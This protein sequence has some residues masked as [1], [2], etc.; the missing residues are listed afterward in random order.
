[1][2]LRSEFEKKNPWKLEGFQIFLE[3][4]LKKTENGTWEDYRNGIDI[5]EDRDLTIARI[6]GTDIVRGGHKDVIGILSVYLKGTLK[7]NIKR[8]YFEDHNNGEGPFLDE[9]DY[10]YELFARMIAKECQTNEALRQKFTSIY[11]ERYPEEYRMVQKFAATYD[12]EKNSEQEVCSLLYSIYTRATNFDTDPNETRGFVMYYFMIE[13]SIRRGIILP[14]RQVAPL[15]WRWKYPG[16]ES[17][18][19]S[20][21]PT[22]CKVY[23][24][25]NGLSPDIITG[26]PD[27][28]KEAAEITMDDFAPSLAALGKRKAVKGMFR[29]SFE[30]RIRK[31]NILNRKYVRERMRLVAEYIGCEFD[32]EDLDLSMRKIAEKM[33]DLGYTEGLWKASAYLAVAEKSYYKTDFAADALERSRDE[34]KEP[35]IDMLANCVLYIHFTAKLEA[36]LKKKDKS[37]DLDNITRHEII[38][39]IGTED[40]HKDAEFFIN[41]SYVAGAFRAQNRTMEI[42]LDACDLLGEANISR[43]GYQAVYQDEIE[44]KARRIADQEAEIA[45]L[46]N[47]IEALS[48][49]GSQKETGSDK[50]LL[51]EIRKLEE[52][53]EKKD[54]EIDEAEKNASE[55]LSYIEMMEAT[56]TD[57]EPEEENPVDM[58]RLRQKRFVFVCQDVDNI[59]P[60][61][62]REFPGSIFME[63]LQA[64]PAKGR[65]D[66]VVF[67]TRHISHSLYYKAKSIYDGRRMI[68]FTKKNTDEMYRL[69]TRELKTA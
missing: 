57:D 48:K 60:D 44:R 7:S 62:R 9:K 39:E 40:I 49:G 15:L 36:I 8:A 5:E 17:T 38:R 69:I 54:K 64:A 25:L 26:S 19:L 67:V 46:K 50:A 61:L 11:I 58:E 16:T 65:I 18:L 33:W 52:I 3:E 28:P 32:K 56:E 31:R 4:N 37:G 10:A 12:N 63:S 53:I 30:E 14:Y 59:Y 34:D 29:L 35:Y 66:A 42:Y 22:I 23:D 68:H 27:D 55:L 47:I 24:R 43:A 51:E 45:S 1:M 41:L 20:G 21:F 13:E 6:L 2:S